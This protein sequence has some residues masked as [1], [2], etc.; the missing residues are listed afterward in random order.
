MTEDGKQSL[1][2]KESL[3]DTTTINANNKTQILRE[4]IIESL[5]LKR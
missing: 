5:S 2:L 1:K 3:R 4:L